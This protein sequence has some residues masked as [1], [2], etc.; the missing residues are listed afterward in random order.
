VSGDVVVDGEPLL[1]ELPRSSKTDFTASLRRLRELPAET[2]L[3]GHGPV[4]GRA[5]AHEII[6]DY[7]ATRGL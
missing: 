4:F 2:I 3:A 5:R 7:L 6:L 1:D